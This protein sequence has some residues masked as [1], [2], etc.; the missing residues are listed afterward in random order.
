MTTSNT[1]ANTIVQQTASQNL[2]GQA[3]SLYMLAFRGGSA[4][5]SLITGLLVYAFGVRIALATDGIIAV[6]AQLSIGRLWR[7][8][9]STAAGAP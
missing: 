2:R 1:L 8:V 9:T 6:V 4:L 5:G 7:D 3:V